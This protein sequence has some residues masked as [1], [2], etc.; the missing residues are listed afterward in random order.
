MEV[1]ICSCPAGRSSK[2]E[3]EATSACSLVRNANGGES[4]SVLCDCRP[5]KH[6]SRKHLCWYLEGERVV[7]QMK[8]V[9]WELRG[10]LWYISLGCITVFLHLPCKRW[11]PNYSLFPHL[12]L[13]AILSSVLVNSIT[14]HPAIHAKNLKIIFVFTFSPYI[15]Y[16][17]VV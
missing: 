12:S 2:W 7:V 11:M 8:L 16:Q 17:Q 14:I 15:I 1:M 6:R 4:L 3:L 9:T 5:W 10:Q 13:K